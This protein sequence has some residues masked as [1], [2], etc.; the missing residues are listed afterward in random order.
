MLKMNWQEA[1]TIGEFPGKSRCTDVRILFGVLSMSDF[2]PVSPKSE[3][4]NTAYHS[5]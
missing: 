4:Y 2:H 5:S 3:N 1:K